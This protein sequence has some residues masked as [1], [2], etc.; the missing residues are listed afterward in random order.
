MHETILSLA[1]AI[2]SPSDQEQPLLESL[3]TC[4]EAQITQRLSSGVTPETCAAAFT[5][6]AAL[7]AAA[8]L[9][10]CRSAGG[11]EQFTAGGVSLRLSADAGGAAAA[12]QHQAETMMAPYFQDDTFAFL[13]VRG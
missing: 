13:G 5:C 11:A 2:T 3:C 8:G 4:A 9:F 1:E 10:S 7:L 12:L 6:A